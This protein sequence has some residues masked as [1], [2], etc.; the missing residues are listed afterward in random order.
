MHFVCAN[1]KG[2]G[3]SMH[4][5]HITAGSTMNHLLSPHAG[6][7]LFR[8]FSIKLHTMKSGWSIV[9]IEG[10]QIIIPNN[11][12]FLSLKIDFV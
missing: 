3:Q 12:V 8:P 7:I 10:S 6:F 9:Y 11:I 1:G 5:V 2:S 4:G